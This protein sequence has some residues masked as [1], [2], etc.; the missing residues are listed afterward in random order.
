MKENN[1]NVY[2]NDDKNNNKSEDARLTSADKDG[3]Y[4]KFKNRMKALFKEFEQDN[5]NLKTSSSAIN[6]SERNIDLKDGCCFI[7]IL[8]INYN[9]C[10]Y[11][12]NSS[13]WCCWKILFIHNPSSFINSFGMFYITF[14]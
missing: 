4:D 14:R 10:L 7:I 5:K 9:R 12:I 1:V 8:L 6:F 13:F 11:C 2:I 3:E